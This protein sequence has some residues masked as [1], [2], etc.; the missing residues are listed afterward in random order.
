MDSNYD[1]FEL[2]E[3]KEDY[4]EPREKFCA[5]MI[6]DG[7]RVVIPEA[8]QLQV[9]IDTDEQYAVYQRACEC[10]IKNFP[11]DPPI[12]EEHPSRSGLPRRHV[13]ITLPF[14]VEPWQRI[15]WQASFGS[16]PMREMLSCFRAWHGDQHPTLFVEAP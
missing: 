2:T 15:A 10:F 12:V 14:A 8:N 3:G 16:D 7:F 11:G 5:R 4:R 13:T 1:L 6:A 9:D